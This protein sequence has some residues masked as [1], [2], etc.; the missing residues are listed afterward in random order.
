MTYICPPMG[1]MWD[2]LEEHSIK[3]FIKFPGVELVWEEILFYLFVASY[4]FQVK[5]TLFIN[6]ISKYAEP[7][8]IKK[9]F[10]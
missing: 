10:E 5:R 3:M 7:E 1:K 4:L 6:G 9:H 8:K 2:F